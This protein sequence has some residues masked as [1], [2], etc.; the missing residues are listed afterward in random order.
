MCVDR[1]TLCMGETLGSVLRRARTGRRLS[2]G[3]VGDQ[4]GYSASWVSRVEADRILPDNAA[5]DALCGVLGLAA[6]DVGREGDDVLHRRTMLGLG[7]GVGLGAV[8]P[9]PAAASPVDPKELVERSLFRLP[10]ARPATR[11]SLAAALTTARTVF[12]EAQYAQLGRT[13]PGLISGSLASNAHDIAA[14]A[15]VLLAQLAIKNY[16][17]MAWV[18]AERARM[19]AEL[20][21][22]PVVMGEAAHSMGVTMRRSGDYQ[23]SIDHL[24]Q[25]AARLGQRP[26]ELAMRGTLLLTASYS[27]A[28]AGWRG[29]AMEFIG[30]A[31][32]T[33]KRQETAAQRLYIP[34]V[35]GEDQT[36]VFRISVHHALG[37]DDQA[38]TYAAK[39][40]PRRLPN[41]ERRGR[42]CMDV[43]RVWQSLDE[44]EK[45]FRTLRVLAQYAPEE[46]TRPKVRAI[47]AELLTSNPDMPGLRRFAQRT[48]APV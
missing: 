43:A 17:G 23:A 6:D 7:L 35:F 36:R 27:A 46:A 38:L 33:A 2:Q 39:L 11:E 22:N 37:Q 44:P 47:T 8:L 20:T 5:L 3:A 28:Q 41:A 18:A 40:D 16:Q 29:P 14:R 1:H 12:H 9:T 15:Y 10:D 32:E 45:A 4:V 25:A 42:M 34:G 19:Q 48:G 26:E 30:E 21:G 24:Q 31:E 13:L